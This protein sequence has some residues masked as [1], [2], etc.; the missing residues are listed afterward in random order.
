MTQ[1]TTP[2]WRP[3]RRRPRAKAAPRQHGMHI[4]FLDCCPEPVGALVTGRAAFTHVALAYSFGRG[5]HAGVTA[6]D[7]KL[8]REN[9]PRLMASFEAE[10]GAFCRSYFAA[11]TYAA[12]VLTEDDEISV[13]LG[14]DLPGES[15]QAV[16]LLLRC[17]QVAYS[18]WHRLA[19]YDRRLCQNMIFSVIEEL[20]R[21]LDRQASAH[22]AANG[23]SRNGTSPNGA[24]ANGRRRPPQGDGLDALI[25]HLE[26]AEEFMLRCATRRAQIRYLKGMLAGTAAVAGTIGLTAAF[27]GLLAGIREVP[28]ELLVVATAGAVGA[29]VSVLSRMSSGTFQMNL[30]TLS[31]EMRSTD[32]SLMGGLRP[33]IGLIFAL[34]GYVLVASALIPMQADAD[35]QIFLYAAVGFLAGFSER[36]AQDMFARSGQSLAGVT[37]DLPGSGPSAC[38]APPPGAAQQ[39]APRPRSRAAN[40]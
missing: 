38:L 30:P 21:R 26:D 35:R 17:Q 8:L 3:R 20:L 32:L 36:V 34:A 40:G 27:V 4:E 22:H 31:F 39:R 11:T 29:F 16:A 7:R 9:F 12:A 23:A 13:V 25:D 15:Q 2:R 19:E 14:C 10:H 28:G 18:A 24:S 1:T 37:G 5:H 6:R 33:L